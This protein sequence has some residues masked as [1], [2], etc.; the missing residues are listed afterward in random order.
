MRHDVAGKELLE[1]IAAD[2]G[3]APAGLD[4]EFV[5]EV[6]GEVG[7]EFSLIVSNFAFRMS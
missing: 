1:R 4:T 3:V 6:I 2:V 5:S 7:C